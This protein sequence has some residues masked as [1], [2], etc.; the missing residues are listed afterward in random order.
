MF[1]TLQTISRY[2]LRLMILLITRARK[3]KTR[4]VSQNQTKQWVS[5]REINIKS[6]IPNPDP[7]PKTGQ[8][9]SRCAH[10]TR[11]DPFQVY[12]VIPIHK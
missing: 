4:K 7:T 2:I 9:G 12:A 8:L 6:P 1:F 5:L 3:V 10:P 11:G